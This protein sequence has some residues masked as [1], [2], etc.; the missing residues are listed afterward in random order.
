MGSWSLQVVFTSYAGTPIRGNCPFKYRWYAG[1]FFQ[2]RDWLWGNFNSYGYLNAVVAQ[3]DGKLIA[4]SAFTVF[5]GSPINHIARL[6]TDGSLDASF[7]PGSGFNSWATSG[8]I[9]PD[10]KIVIDWWALRL[11]AGMLPTGLSGL[12]GTIDNSFNSQI[13]ANSFNKLSGIQG[14]GKS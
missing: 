1:Q 2:S 13:G 10:G 5:N 9:Q 3:P 7:N 12:D 6:N 14:T 4:A 8:A 11:S